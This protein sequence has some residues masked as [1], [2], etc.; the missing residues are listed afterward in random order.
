MDTSRVWILAG[1]CSNYRY[2]NTDS[3][4][5]YGEKALNLARQIKFL[6]GEAN[7]LNR[8]SQ[9]FLVIGDLPRALELQYSALKISEDNNFQLEKSSLPE[10]DWISLYGVKK[11]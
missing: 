6:R 5:F 9:T 11:L 4:V 10:T 8:L 7:T 3:S 2:S 1:L